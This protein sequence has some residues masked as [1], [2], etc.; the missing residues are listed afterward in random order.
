MQQQ[1][2]ADAIYPDS[3]HS[4][5]SRPEPNFPI[6]DPPKGQL[7]GSNFFVVLA[8]ETGLYICT[9]VRVGDQPQLSV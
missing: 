6:S 2:F 3:L 4:I 9:R 1:V 7:T 8:R 5:E